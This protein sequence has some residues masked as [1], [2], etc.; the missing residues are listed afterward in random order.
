MDLEQA[1]LEHIHLHLRSGDP[2]DGLLK[3]YMNSWFAHHS[4][5]PFLH[6]GKGNHA[7]RPRWLSDKASK[8][9]L[10]PH[11]HAASKAARTAHSDGR[12]EE[13]VIDHTIPSAELVQSLKRRTFANVNELRAFLK[14]RFTLTL[15]TK[16]EHGDRLRPFKSAMTD[17]WSDEAFEANSSL[18]YCR[19]SDPS[20]GIA[21]DMQRP[22]EG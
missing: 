19:Y 16:H 17:V 11:L 9:L 1:Y 22:H 2:D 7:G 13:L 3:T 15:L 21:F 8:K 12:F 18:R 14:S 5:G 10:A 6:K 20:V 4:G